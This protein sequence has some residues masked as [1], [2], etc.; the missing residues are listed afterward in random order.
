[1]STL[2]WE[3]SKYEVTIE[4]VTTELA[5]QYLMTIKNQRDISK[6]TVSLY[7]ELLQNKLWDILNGDAIKFDNEGH[8]IDGQHRLSAVVKSGIP[9]VTFVI[10]GIRKD[11]FLSGDKGK[12]RTLRDT[13]KMMGKKNCSDLATALRT[14]LIWKKGNLSFITKCRTLTL[15]DRES[16]NILEEHPYIEYMVTCGKT[17]YDQQRIELIKPKYIIYYNYILPLINKKL[18]NDFINI[19][20]GKEPSENT[21]LFPLLNMAAELYKNK[22]PRLNP[23]TSEWF[24][25]INNC[26][27]LFIKGQ[28]ADKISHIKWD[29][30]TDF[31]ELLNDEYKTVTYFDLNYKNNRLVVN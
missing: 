20:I 18:S 9:I 3:N 16:I 1:M 14:L 28:R 6:N 29:Y 15:S 5:K 17:V 21:P 8:L 2:E 31:P 23:Y 12:R 11:M 10:R 4:R 24:A 19:L 25:M 13:L 27:N 7:K 30:H 26:W 22:N